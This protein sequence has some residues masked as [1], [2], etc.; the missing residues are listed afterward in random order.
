MEANMA[1]K[2]AVQV[3]GLPE[4]PDYPTSP[5][6]AWKHFG[7]LKALE[8]KFHAELVQLGYVGHLVGLGVTYTV[9]GDP[10][11]MEYGYGVENAEGILEDKADPLTDDFVGEMYDL[12]NNLIAQNINPYT[13]SFELQLSA[14]VNPQIATVVAICQVATAAN[15]GKAACI[16]QCRR[17]ISRNNGPWVCTHKKGTCNCG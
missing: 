5:L 17:F 13:G 9:N 1:R 15:C 2:T 7:I 3:E 14:S 11:T 6:S 16:G 10:F 4:I 8:E 12:A